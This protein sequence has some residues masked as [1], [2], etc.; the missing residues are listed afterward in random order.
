[1][2]A[3]LPQ[4]EAMRLAAL[5]E[6]GILDTL[7]EECYDDITH[8]AAE[9]CKT[10]IALVSLVDSDRQWFKSK[11]GLETSATPRDVAFCA[12]AIHDAELLIVPD[13]MDDDRFSDNPLV[14]AGPKIR[15][16]AGAPLVTPNGHALGTLCVIDTVDRDL[17]SRQTTSLRALSRQVMA[18]LELRRH[19]LLLNEH[20][21]SLAQ[22]MQAL[23]QSNVRLEE[24]SL[25]DDVSG[26][27]NTRFLH[28][29]LDRVLG[30]LKAG[31]HLS[32]V[33]FDMD[34]FKTVVDRY[35][36]LL[37]SKVL[38][39]VA[40]AVHRLLG[41]EDRI[42]RY[43]GDEYVIIL[44]GQSAADARGTTERI[45]QC[46]SDTPFLCEENIGVRVTAS[47]GL[48]T[49]PTD[50]VSKLELLRQADN[51]LFRSKS[52]GRNRIWD[53]SAKQ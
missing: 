21:Q 35:G 24:A 36:H 53:Q 23:E 31:E 40:N 29:H 47:F 33:F 28:L 7:P 8:L 48:A 15:F 16:Y 22:A 1:M 5:R 30:D 19:V 13:A 39:E 20:R 38:R 52:Q 4:N 10:P 49:C 46:I 25:R 9:I 51:Y 12:H 37:A 42:V 43:G 50:A 2:K 26:F 27:H 3:E 14:N 11:K 6:Y 34:H 44:P 41:P 32:L 45:R 18:Q 17:S